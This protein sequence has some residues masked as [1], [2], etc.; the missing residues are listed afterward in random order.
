MATVSPVR[1]LFRDFPLGSLVLALAAA[2]AGVR[3]LSPRTR[4][5][6]PAEI[7]LR[8]YFSDEEIRRGARFARPQVALGLARTAIDAGVLAAVALRARRAVPGRGRAVP[9]RGR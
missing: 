2:E 9:G 8:D 7:D 6:A 5:V 4:P 3:L 1:R